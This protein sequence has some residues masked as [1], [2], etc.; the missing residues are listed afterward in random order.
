M[1]KDFEIES[2]VA[3]TLEVAQMLSILDACIERKG[4]W[5]TGQIIPTAATLSCHAH[6]V[7][8]RFVFPI[9]ARSLRSLDSTI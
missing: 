8:K 2:S 1:V 9:Y 6:F 4:I 3:Y 5:Q 7:R